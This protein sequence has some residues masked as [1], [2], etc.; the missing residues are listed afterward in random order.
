MTCKCECGADLKVRRTGKQGSASV[1]CPTCGKRWCYSCWTVKETNK[2]RFDR[3][4][5]FED[6]DGSLSEV[7]S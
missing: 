3:V 6:Q 4:E 7:E 2:A 1:T 5:L